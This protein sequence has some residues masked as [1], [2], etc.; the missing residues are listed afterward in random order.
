MM[1]DFSSPKSS[2]VMVA[3]VTKPGVD[4]LATPALGSVSDPFWLVHELLNK[5]AL[6]RE[7]HRSALELL[8]STKG[9]A[10]SV[11][12][13]VL[14]LGL[15]TP[16]TLAELY[17][18]AYKLATVDLSV[19]GC[20]SAVAKLLPKTRASQVQAIPFRRHEKELH[21]AVADPAL[22]PRAVVGAELNN[23]AVRLF[24]APKKEILNLIDEIWNGELPDITKE[25]AAAYV[26]RTLTLCVQERA[27]DIHFEPKPHSL[28]IRK[29]IDGQLSHHAYVQENQRDLVVNAVK[30]LAGL[31]TSE[32]RKTADGQAKLLIGSRMYSFRVSTAPT[33]FGQNA[34]LR[35][36]DESAY[37]RS[38]SDQGLSAQNEALIR[39]LVK[40]STGVII[41]T[42]PTGSGKTTTLHAMLGLLDTPGS[43]IIAI[44]D[45][46]E[47]ENPRFTQLP[48]DPDLG[49]TFAA[50]LRAALR[51]DPDYI[52][53]GEIRD[54][55][56]ATV[57]IQAALT[58]HL[59]FT[60]LHTNDAIAAITRLVDIG[61]DPFLVAS[62]VKAV[63]AQ[64]LIPLLCEEC[65]LPHPALDNMRAQFG[66]PHANYRVPKPAGCPKCSYDGTYRRVGVFE[67]FPLRFDHSAQ[68]NALSAKQNS[69]IEP[70]DLRIRVVASGEASGDLTDLRRSREEIFSRFSI[71][72]DLERKKETEVVDLITHGSGDSAIRDVYRRRGYPTLLSD[73]LEKAANGRI[74]LEHIFANLG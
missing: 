59:V 48:V 23:Q 47:Y 37:H 5:G 14:S 28:D 7:Q 53:V 72:I 73:A 51:Q 44:E 32:K 46:I 10:Q 19:C 24:V 70:L 34:V 54:R 39:Q 69:E 67:V 55:E 71:L 18:K 16:L 2:S 74:S 29:R 26:V 3:P 65:S 20:D 38:L 30:N 60:T 36:M 25:G 62:T 42:G 66:A 50:L 58:G 57:T 21:V 27:S 43:K 4:R 63:S 61:V 13:T 17:A 40:G 45:P 35:I 9:K 33:V 41:C 56:V 49:N 6:T 15:T 22:F 8:T 1:P 68:I 64:R 52:L 31:D 11:A 12:D